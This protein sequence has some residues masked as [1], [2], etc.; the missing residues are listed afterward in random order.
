MEERNDGV[1]EKSILPEW[2]EALC[3]MEL[4]RIGSNKKASCSVGEGWS[5]LWDEG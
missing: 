4:V 5:R 2:S 1:D 3:M